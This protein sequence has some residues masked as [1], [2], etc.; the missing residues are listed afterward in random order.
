MLGPEKNPEFHAGSREESGSADIRRKGDWRSMS[1]SV[2][3]DFMN[4]AWSLDIRSFQR[5]H[6][7]NCT[8]EKNKSESNAITGLRGQPL[9]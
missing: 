2:M 5:M 1:G 7:Q 6:N 4:H 3:K 8:L 9:V